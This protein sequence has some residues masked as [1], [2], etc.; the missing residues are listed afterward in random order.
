MTCC[1]VSCGGQ[2]GIIFA[3]DLLTYVFVHICFGPDVVKK[4]V[5]IQTFGNYLGFLVQ[6]G[7]SSMSANQPQYSCLWQLSIL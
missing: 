4:F 1:I 2:S 6:C 5:L 3:A 7:T